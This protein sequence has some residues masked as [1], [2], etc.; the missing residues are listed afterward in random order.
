MRCVSPFLLLLKSWL[1]LYTT[2]SHVVFKLLFCLTSSDYPLKLCCVI[3][4]LYIII[5]AS[6]HGRKTW[7]S[8]IWTSQSVTCRL[9]NIRRQCFLK[10]STQ[11]LILGSIWK[12]FRQLPT[13][14]IPYVSKLCF[15]LDYQ[16]WKC[17]MQPM[18][19]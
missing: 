3:L 5:T 11:P 2:T 17:L 9:Q 1:V 15:S 13:M 8:F 4:P 18:N 10:S 12:Y 19:I 7:F 14:T 6:F 16:V